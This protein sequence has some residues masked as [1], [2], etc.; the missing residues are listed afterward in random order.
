[1]RKTLVRTMEK[2]LFSARSKAQWKN[3]YSRNGNGVYDGLF[4]RFKG[5][6]GQ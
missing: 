4:M 1:M 2:E 6:N 5:E 3:S